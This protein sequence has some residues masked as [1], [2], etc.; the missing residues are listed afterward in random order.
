MRGVATGGAGLDFPFL[1]P[2]G[3]G[4]VQALA[5]ELGIDDL[6]VVQMQERED[7]CLSSLWA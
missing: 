6:S 4:C 3:A 1:K 2:V 5:W 7:A